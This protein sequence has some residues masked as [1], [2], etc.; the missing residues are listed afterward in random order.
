MLSRNIDRSVLLKLIRALLNEEEIDEVVEIASLDP[1][2]V[3]KILEYVNSA[4]FSLRKRITSIRDA[5]TFLGYKHLKELA[6]SLLLS[7]LLVDKDKKEILD[8]VKFSYFMKFLAKELNK[9][10]EEE[11]FSVAILYPVYREKGKEVLDTIK[12]LGFPEIVL[13]GLIDDNSVLGKLRLLT[14]KLLPICEKL[15]SK[16]D[17]G[18]KV[19]NFPLRKL[20]F[21]CIM[22]DRET[23]KLKNL[24]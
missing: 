1:V 15:N 5:V 24:L 4:F 10:L 9:S 21:A 2:L 14:K 19:K 23:L 3:E 22:A 7:Q 17:K 11:A 12:N 18:V 6:F 13:E 20:I 8:F 16:H